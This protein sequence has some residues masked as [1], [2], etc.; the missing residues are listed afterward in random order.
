[1]YDN[2]TI[3]RRRVGGTVIIMTDREIEKIFELLES[4]IQF[5]ETS[6]LKAVIPRKGYNYIYHIA[7]YRASKIHFKI[8]S[9]FTYN[10]QRIEFVFNHHTLWYEEK[11]YDSSVWYER[12]KPYLFLESIIDNYLFI[13]Y[14]KIVNE[15]T[16]LLNQTRNGNLLWKED[17]G[18]LTVTNPTEKW[19]QEYVLSSNGFHNKHGDFLY[20]TCIAYNH[21]QNLSYDEVDFFTD[22]Y[23]ELWNS[24]PDIPTMKIVG[25]E[26]D[27]EKIQFPATPVPYPLD[28]EKS[29][30][31][32]PTSVGTCPEA[33]LKIISD[34]PITDAERSKLSAWVK[35][36]FCLMGQT[37]IIITVELTHKSTD[38]TNKFLSDILDT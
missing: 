4:G 7:E 13:P 18:K 17:H 19:M 29:V 6:K 32:F 23:D 1:M 37:P 22:I 21:I 15:L 38:N 33:A 3:G 10:A 12:V 8:V 30:V 36:E 27:M 11:R 16:E 24:I 28:Y 34:R 2:I 9:Q 5:K 26:L 31:G 14:I 25:V 20:E 35:S